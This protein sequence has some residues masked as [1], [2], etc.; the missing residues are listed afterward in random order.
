MF[1]LDKPQGSQPGEVLLYVIILSNQ[2]IQYEYANS[3]LLI[4]IHSST[5]F[6]LKVLKGITR[7]L[8]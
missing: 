3:F 8:Q 4:F 5:D 6:H 1:V 7:Y 2:Q